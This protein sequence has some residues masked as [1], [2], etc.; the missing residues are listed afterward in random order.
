VHGLCQMYH[1]LKSHV[2][3]TRWYYMV[4]RL[5]WKHVSVCLE[6]VLI[7]MQDSCSVCADR[8]IGI[9]IILDAPDGTPR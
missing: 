8:I 4:T 2:G 1:R 7:S 5:K 3:H 6:I 9:E